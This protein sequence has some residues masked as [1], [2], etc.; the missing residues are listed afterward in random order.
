MYYPKNMLSKLNRIPSR[1]RLHLAAALFFMTVAFIT[2]HSQIFNTG[3]HGAGY[4]YFHFHW[5]FWWIRYALSHGYDI[6]QTNFVMFPHVVNLGFHTLSLFWFPLWAILEPLIGTLAAMT[7]IVFVGS[8]FNGYC[9]FFWLR[10]KRIHVGL[11]LLSGVVLQLAPVVRY[12]YYNTHINL[13]TWFWIPLHLLV[14]DK[15]V[16]AI[17][18]AN[19]KRAA[20]LTSLL[21]IM[22]WMMTLSDLQ[23]PIFLGM[24]I[25]P[26]ALISLWQSANRFRLLGY[27]IFSVIASQI[28]LWFAGPLPYLFDSERENFVPGTVEGRPSV[29]L[30]DG[31]LKMS[32]TWWD[33]QTPSIG[34]FVTFCVILS[35]V[36]PLVWGRAKN[37]QLPRF[38]WFW[39]L[40]LIPPLIITLGPSLFI[41]NTEIKLPYRTI[42][43]LTDGNFRMPWRLVPVVVIAAMVFFSRTWSSFVS[44]RMVVRV[45]SFGLLFFLIGVDLR[46]FETAPLIPVVPHYQFYETIGQEATDLYTIVEVPTGAGTGEILIGNVDAIPYQYYGIVH[47]KPMI[48]GFV[49]R[50]P[51]D[52]FWYLRTDDPMLSWLGQ[53]RNLEPE[54]VEAQLRERIDSWPLGYIVIHKDLIGIN[55]STPQEII[56]YFNTLPDLLCPV[57]IEGEAIVYRTSWHPDSCPPRTPPIIDENTYQIDMGAPDDQRFMGWGW[58][59]AESVFDTTFRWA[60]E[61]PTALL[62][63]DLPP[64]TYNLEIITQAFHEPRHVDVMVNGQNIGNLAVSNESLQA[65]VLRVPAEIIGDGKHVAIEFVYDGWLVSQELGLSGDTRRLAMMV[66]MI[67]F[68]KISD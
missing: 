20:F 40:I 6:F 19:T 13:M 24:I 47:E 57:F 28:L 10:T 35:I 52:K 64:A 15:L 18:H 11:A 8:V 43:N 14:W 36:L 21:A 37:H 39:L 67:R 50:A 34:A 56:G 31:F 60:G 12:F 59:W 65:Y 42:F 3:T 58:H 61:Y 26:Y 4:D 32:D 30:P 63:V 25:G 23:M 41:G 66:D 54:N 46:I 29:T 7:M 48:N 22:L 1:I 2:L 16:D 55:T 68:S 5:N 51:I 62:Y 49:A 38:R 53:R 44:Q 27:A 9:F 17:D 45:F 33:W